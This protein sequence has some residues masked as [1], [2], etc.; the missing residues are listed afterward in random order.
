MAVLP[1]R[2]AVPTVLSSWPVPPAMFLLSVS[3]FLSPNFPV[4]VVLS[5]LSCSVRPFPSVLSVYPVPAV[6]S[7]MPSCHVLAVMFWTSWPR[8]VWPVH[9]HFSGQHVQ[10][11]MSQLSCLNYPVPVVLCWISCNSYPVP[12]ALAQ[13]YPSGQPLLF[14]L[15]RLVW[16]G[17]PFLPICLDWPVQVVL[18]KLSCPGQHALAALSI[19]VLSRLSCISCPVPAVLSQL[20]CPIKH[21]SGWSVK[22]LWLY[23]CEILLFACKFLL[24]WN[25]SHFFRF[26][27]KFLRKQNSAKF[28]EIPQNVSF[29]RKLEE[30]FS[31]QP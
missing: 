30:A 22:L 12:V 17:W 9:A 20:S 29:L 10:A 6:L 8:P 14:V 26:L 16:S 5:M 1:H 31:F 24:R 28:R 15:F 27:R 18:Y 13:P 2:Y 11:D 4:P 21:K 3:V 7:W 25:F 19:A 23:F